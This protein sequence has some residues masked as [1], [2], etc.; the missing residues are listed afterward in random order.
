MGSGEHTAHESLNIVE[1]GFDDALLLLLRLDLNPTE[2]E[3][4]LAVGA[5]GLPDEFFD[6]DVFFTF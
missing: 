4:G 6:W 2:I 3:R 1:R 5:A